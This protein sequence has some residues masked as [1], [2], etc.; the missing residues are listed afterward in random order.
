MSSAETNQP[1]FQV[2]VTK[3]GSTYS[4]TIESKGMFHK[5]IH[6]AQYGMLEL[7]YKDMTTKNATLKIKED[8]LCF[9]DIQDTSGVEE[10]LR[11]MNAITTHE[12]I[13]R[14]LR[15]ELLD[16]VNAMGSAKIT[17][18]AEPDLIVFKNYSNVSL[19]VNHDFALVFCQSNPEQGESCIFEDK[20]K[21]KFNQIDWDND[22]TNTLVSE[23]KEYRGLRYIEDGVYEFSFDFP[24]DKERIR[25]HFLVLARILIAAE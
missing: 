11:V 22:G 5:Y 18:D 4:L 24:Q 17:M 20:M 1:D 25:E 14:S 6:T 16:A 7:C 2:S 15:D 9:T 21:F 19:Y 3:S 8:K 12:R 23:G 13:R 10:I